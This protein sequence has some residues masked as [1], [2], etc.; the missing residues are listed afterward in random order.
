MMDK[1]FK[2]IIEPFRIKMVEPIKMTT[3]AERQ[4]YLQEAHHNVFLIR[5]ENILIDLLTDSGT[6]AMSAAQWAKMMEGD[7]SYAGCR[8]YYDMRD[9]IVDLTG[10]KHV[11]PT[12]Q[13][14]AAERILFTAIGG[15][16]KII[17]NNT[18]FDTTRANVE[19]T[20]AEA[21]D[22]VIEEGKDPSS[23]HPFKGN[24][25][26]EKLEALFEKH[27]GT[28]RIPLCMITV[29]NNSGGGQ[30]VSLENIR[31]TKQL[32]KKY[33]I[34][35][36]LDCCRFAENAYFI[37]IREPGQQNRTVKEIVKEMFSYSDGATMSSKKDALVNMGGFL[38]FNDDGLAQEVQNLEILTEGYP[39]YGG[40]SGRDLAAL[41]QGLKEVVEEDYLEYR[42]KSTQYLGDALVREG[43]PVMRPIGGHAVYIDA[44]AMLPHIPAHEL[45]AQALCCEC[46]L[47]GGI[48]S[49]EIGTLMFGRPNPNGGTDIPS[50]MELLRLAIPRRVY[51]QSHIDYVIEAIAFVNKRKA[52]LKG[53]KITEQPPYLRHFT[54]K[55][56]PLN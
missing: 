8:S 51:T 41:G 19:Y 39:T 35:L 43:V 6:G 25:D 23:E 7:E 26:L 1:K 10:F 13:G 40:L 27:R 56:A 29:T 24:M 21:V 12:H 4:R 3:L 53:L 5:A 52:N 37:K 47:E 17:P 34:P 31:Q 15:P 33:N 11:F 30:P 14:R 54:A 20:K 9:S 38:A 48:R 32:C 50:A 2:T 28:N 46:Y 16:D 42:I 18:H 22:L 55:M 44:K 49:V 45:P 36:F